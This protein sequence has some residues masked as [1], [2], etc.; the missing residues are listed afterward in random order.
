MAQRT[1]TRWWLCTALLVLTALAYTPTLKYPWIY[2]DANWLGAIAEPVIAWHVPGRAL[3]MQTFHWTWQA[4]GL[5]PFGYRLGNVA[6][7]LVNG[8]LVYA[9]A[10]TL[11][12]GAAAVWG[13]GVFLLHPLNSEAVS[14]VSA[15]TDLLSTTFILL[16]VWLC[17]GRVA[18]WRLGLI[19]AALVGAALSKETGVLGVPLVVVTLLIWRP[20]LPA[21][22]LVAPLWIGLGAAIGA[23]W[24]SVIAWL[25]MPSSA[26]GTFFAWPQFA[27]LQLTAA[28]HLLSLLLWPDGFSIDH[29]VLALGSGW[30]VAAVLLTISAGAAIAL[31]WRRAPVVAWALAWVGITIVPRLVFRTTE[32]LHEYQMYLALAALSV[33]AGATMSRLWMWHPHP[34]ARVLPIWFLADLRREWQQSGLSRRTA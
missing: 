15:R 33:L 7:H 14:Y 24:S 9:I 32:F 2:E 20:Q 13:A 18:I 11:I 23:M 4:V 5:E 3:T 1:T 31:G 21:S 29:D 28:W 12:P 22:A 16:A 27:V 30:A 25:S 10:A 17:L 6:I 34:L 19:G 26:G 8:A